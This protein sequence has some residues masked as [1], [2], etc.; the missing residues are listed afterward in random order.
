MWVVYFVHHF[1]SEVLYFGCRVL[2]GVGGGALDH[3]KSEIYFHYCGVPFLSIPMTNHWKGQDKHYLFFCYIILGLNAF[4]MASWNT[5]CTC[6]GVYLPGGGV[7]VWEGCTCPRVYL[8]RGVCIPAC[9]EADTPLWTEWLTD[10]CENITLP[11][12]FC[13]R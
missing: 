4:K 6:W 13:G 11:Q 3:L 5:N 1:K 7:L 10:A 12:L 9:T 8:S 2:V